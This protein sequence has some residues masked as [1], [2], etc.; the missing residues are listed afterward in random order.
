L[1]VLAERAA[2][3]AAVTNAITSALVP[4]RASTG[5]YQLEVESRYVVATA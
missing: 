2:G 4:Y 1:T 5:G 3:E